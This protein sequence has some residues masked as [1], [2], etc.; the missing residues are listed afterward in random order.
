MIIFRKLPNGSTEQTI[1]PITRTITLRTRWPIVAL[2]VFL[3]LAI[4]LPHR[5]WSMLAVTFALLLALTYGWARVI[6]RGLTAERNLRWRWVSVGDKLSE[7]FTLHNHS[8]LPAFWVEVR[9]QSN[10]P[11]Y[12]AAAIRSVD[13][14][15]KVT[16][17]EQA[18]CTQRGRYQ[19]GPWSIHSSDPLGFFELQIKYAESEEIIIHPPILH[20]LPLNLPAGHGRGTT[21]RQRRTWRSTINVM[22]IRAYQPHDPLHHIDWKGSAKTGALQVKQF[23]QDSA[24]DVWLLLDMQQT[25]QLGS[26]SD[27]TEEQTILLAAALAARSLGAN[28]Q[29]GVAA[30]TNNPLLIAPSRSSDQRWHIL[31]GLALISAESPTPLDK[32]ILDLSQIVQSGAAIQ[33]ITPNLSNTWLPLL[34]NLTVRGCAVSVAVFDRASFDGRGNLAGIQSALTHMN[35][36]FTVIRRGDIRPASVNKAGRSPSS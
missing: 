17:H 23:E 24:G 14:Q 29:I 18:I 5:A 35:I 22:S 11:G 2:G 20:N 13:P 34:T 33:I 8:W 26:D 7:Q 27:S 1:M 3:L 19:L 6:V 9:D 12:R 31:H 36:P 10:V 21:K 16:W 25:V 15:R 32:A 4:L 30:Y 28:R